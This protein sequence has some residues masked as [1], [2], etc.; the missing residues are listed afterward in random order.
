MDLQK[1]YVIDASSMGNIARFINH[2][3]NPN[4]TVEMWIV[5]EEPRLAIFAKNQIASGEELTFNYNF[6]P[7][8]SS[9]NQKCHCESANCSKI[10]T[11]RPITPIVK[12]CC[13]V[14]FS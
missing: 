13:I 3:C 9:K 11:K 5:D 1:G 7:F 8:N 14:L 10:Q 12:V 6:I 2:S 4:S